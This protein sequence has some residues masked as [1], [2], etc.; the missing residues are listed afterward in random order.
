M[1]PVSSIG[2]RCREVMRFAQGHAGVGSEHVYWQ[3]SRVRLPG[4]NTLALPPAC[5]M[6]L[7]KLFCLCLSLHYVK[8]S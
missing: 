2:N 6:A 1:I 3:G 5:P 7:G 8:W 4:F